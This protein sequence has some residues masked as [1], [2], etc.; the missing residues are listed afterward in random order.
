MRILGETAL[1]RH[2][3][4]RAQTI[5]RDAIEIATNLEMRRLEADCRL[6]LG[7]SL[8]SAGDLL[9][10]ES[11]LARAR[12]LYEA[13]KLMPQFALASSLSSKPLSMAPLPPKPADH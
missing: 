1:A 5:F 12:A 9:A 8:K 7:Q 13:M 10:A 2:D 4:P 11:E 3:Q 6:G